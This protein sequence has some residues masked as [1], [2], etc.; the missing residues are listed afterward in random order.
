MRILYFEDE[1]HISFRDQG[2]VELGFHNFAELLLIFKCPPTSRVLNRRNGFG[3]CTRC[4]SRH[5]RG[6]ACPPPPRWPRLT[7]DAICR[8]PCRFLST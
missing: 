1:G 6:R 8:M 4:R 3:T 2:E 5:G 7:D